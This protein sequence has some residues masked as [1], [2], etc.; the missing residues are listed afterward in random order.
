MSDLDGHFSREVDPNGVWVGAGTGRTNDPRDALQRLGGDGVDMHESLSGF[1]GESDPMRV[2]FEESEK[3][4]FNEKDAALSTMTTAL[5]IELRTLSLSDHL[6]TLRSLSAVLINAVKMHYPTIAYDPEIFTQAYSLFF[7]S[8]LLDV[9]RD[10]NGNDYVFNNIPESGDLVSF[11][12]DI[13]NA[14]Y[15]LYELLH[16][17]YKGEHYNPFIDSASDFTTPAQPMAIES[18]DINGDKAPVPPPTIEAEFNKTVKPAALTPRIA[19]M[20]ASIIEVTSQRKDLFDAISGEVSRVQKQ[21]ELA[22]LPGALPLDIQEAIGVQFKDNPQF[23]NNL[24]AVMSALGTNILG[25]GYVGY[26]QLFSPEHLYS[27]MRNTGFDISEDAF[28]QVTGW[29]QRAGIII[30]IGHRSSMVNTIDADN[31]FVAGTG[32][33]ALIHLINQN[34]LDAQLRANPEDRPVTFSRSSFSQEP[35]SGESS[36]PDLRTLSP[37]ARFS[38]LMWH[39]RF[40]AA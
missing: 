6:F 37:S 5:L 21:Q 33:Q 22:I 40:S 26:F 16:A 38:S 20:I 28:N 19:A 23:A 13:N 10:K 3:L 4:R 11:D 29:M 39:L 1:L 15:P 30:N 32:G 17:A 27:A 9:S 8:H 34:P 36:S 12:G 35:F 2:V 25:Q 18:A 7:K 24:T 31:N 14:D